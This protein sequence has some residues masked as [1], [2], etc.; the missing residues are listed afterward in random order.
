MLVAAATVPIVLV[1]RLVSVGAP[2]LLLRPV[3]DLGA[4]ALPILWWGGLRGGVSIALALSIAPGPYQELILTATYANV[5]F[6]VVVQGITIGRVVA[7]YRE[8][9][10]A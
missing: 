10:P 1:A 6:S 3:Q 9:E 7:R 5:F 8:G 4:G 2:L